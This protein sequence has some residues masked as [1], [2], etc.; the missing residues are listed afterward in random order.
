M[1]NLLVK[2][3]KKLF[4]N[5]S[6][7]LFAKVEAPK[8]LVI[9]LTNICN[10]NCPLCVTGLRLQK[11]NKQFMNYELFTQIIEKI[12][13]FK[14]LVQLYK[15]GESLLHKDLVK[16]LEHC[17]KYDLNT[18]ISS[19]LSLYNIDEKLEA[20]VKFRLKHL[21]IS[22]D[23]INQEDYS[24][25]R[26]G[27]DFNLVLSNLKKL[28][29]SKKKYNSNYPIVSLQYL[30]SKYTTNQVD[31]IDKNYRTWGADRYYACDMTTIFKDRDNNK[32]LQW[33]SEEEIAKRKYLDV[34]FSMLGEVCPFLYNFMIVEQDGSMPPC[35]WATDPV[36]DFFQWDNSMTIKQMYTTIKFK[37]ARRC[38]E[39]RVLVKSLPCWNCSILI[40][41][42]DKENLKFN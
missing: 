29:D 17:N 14:G 37:K 42:L 6:V 11:K 12:K 15:W 22:F 5:N 16:I 31:V 20:M 8:I 35:C 2:L 9:G 34:N 32:A 24:R 26:I 25:Y 38:F 27:G 18:E 7:I 10:L 23:G 41:Y 13:D 39:K 28:S 33:F 36:D 19:N 21:I 30:R 40:S 3:I 1:I 4:S